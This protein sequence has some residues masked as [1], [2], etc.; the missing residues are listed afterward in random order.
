MSQCFSDLV[1]VERGDCGV[2]DD[3]NSLSDY[4]SLEEI[5]LVEE[6]GADVDRVAPVTEIDFDDG[7]ELGDGRP[8]G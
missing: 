7:G 2:G 4:V 3:E 6:A 1:E 5:G 8:R